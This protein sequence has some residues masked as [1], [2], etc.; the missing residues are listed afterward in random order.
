MWELKIVTLPS[1][2]PWPSRWS[3]VKRKGERKILRTFRE[4]GMGKGDVWILGHKM[5]S[6]QVACGRAHPAYTICSS[7]SAAKHFLRGPRRRING[8]RVE[9]A[10]ALSP[11]PWVPNRSR[12]CEPQERGRQLS[13]NNPFSMWYIVIYILIDVYP[14]NR[15]SYEIK[16]SIESHHVP[17][18]LITS[19][20]LRGSGKWKVSVVCISQGEV[21]GREGLY[22]DSYSHFIVTENGE[23][24]EGHILNI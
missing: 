23:Q 18:S 11:S 3:G 20:V 7:V 8:L 16:Y 22:R 5:R 14:C 19:A 21:H 24:I 12:C 17:T 15:D 9:I 4:N 6:L 13:D 1:G 10:E 2:S